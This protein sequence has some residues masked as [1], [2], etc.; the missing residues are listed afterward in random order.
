M[1][2]S[3][4]MNNYLQLVCPLVETAATGI[5]QVS[6]A[7]AAV[8]NC[9]WKMDGKSK[10][11]R[12]SCTEYCG[13][14]PAGRDLVNWCWHSTRWLHG[15]GRTHWLQDKIQPQTFNEAGNVP[16]DSTVSMA[17]VLLN[18]EINANISMLTCLH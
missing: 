15:V 8:H 18:F 11:K 16:K 4:I 5:S 2:R 1:A 6:V 3:A 9:R 13:T 7:Q 12:L 14:A 10:P 17:L